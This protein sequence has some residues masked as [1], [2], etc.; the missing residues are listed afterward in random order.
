MLAWLD[1]TSMLCA[2][3][4]RGAASRAKLVSPAAAI[5]SRPARS[6]GLSMPTSAAPLF[7]RSSSSAA[8]A[9]L[10]PD[11]VALRLQLLGRLRRRGDARLA[12]RRLARHP[13]EH[14]LVSSPVQG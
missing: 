2:R 9:R 14:V 1:S 6:N 5:A 10:D 12:G 3:V 11:R 13:D 8:G 4:V 7:I